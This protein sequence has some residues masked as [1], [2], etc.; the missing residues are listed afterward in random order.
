[1]AEHAQP[2]GVTTTAPDDGDARS[3][4]RQADRADL[5]AIYRI[6]KASFPQP[7][8]YEVFDRFL[9]EPGFLVAI[10]GEAVVGYVVA[11]VV[12][13]HGRS[14]GHVKDLA[15]HPDRR[16]RGY[17]R[18]LLAHSLTRL[19]EADATSAKLEVREGN[20]PAKHLYRDFGFQALRRV[21]GYYDDG[22]NA[23]VMVRELDDWGR[24]DRDYGG[25]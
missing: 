7:W 13:N 9:G 5:L 14:F 20:E 25:H 10:E 8:P 18:R 17:G 23:L 21:E 16:G 2:P 6:E 11:D 22:E 15:V 12:P 1:M 3:R 19:A 24:R 4:I